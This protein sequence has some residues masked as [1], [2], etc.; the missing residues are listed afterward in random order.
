MNQ[1]LQKAIQEYAQAQFNLGAA[2]L[3]LELA[4]AAIIKPEPATE[5]QE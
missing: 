5:E 4:L 1:D 3:K 2:T